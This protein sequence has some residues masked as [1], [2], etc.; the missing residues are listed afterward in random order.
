MLKIG[1]FTFGGGYAMLALLENEFV[2]K[3]KWLDSEEFID[4]TTIAESTPGPIAINMATYIGYKKGKTLGAVFSTIGV[5]LPSF[6]IIFAISLFFDEFL[7][8]KWIAAAFKGIQICVVFLIFS[9]GLKS[10]KKMKKTPFNLMVFLGTMGCCI[11]FSLFSVRFS[12]IFY[13]LISAVVG[14]LLFSIKTAREKNKKGET[15]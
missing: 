14:V 6:L 8:I 11:A 5:C 7:A 10:L 13:I 1:V 3:K 12:S 15:P 9:A 4:L 2:G